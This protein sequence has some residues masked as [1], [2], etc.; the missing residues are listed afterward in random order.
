MISNTDL[1]ELRRMVTNTYDE[2]KACI[3]RVLQGIQQLVNENNKLKGEIQK[4]NEQLSVK[5]VC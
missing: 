3:Q 5:S 4:L 2:D 1:N